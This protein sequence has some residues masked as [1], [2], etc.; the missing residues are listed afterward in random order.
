[1]SQNVHEDYW[2]ISEME[3]RFN[4]TQSGVRTVASTW[5]LAAFGAI[6]VLIRSEDGVTWFFHSH[7]LIVVVSTMASLGLFAL[8]I[9]DQV[10]FQRLLNSAFLVG[11]KMEHD[12]PTIPPV[13]SVMTYAAEGVGMSRWL[14][15]FYFMPMIAFLVLSSWLTLLFD[16]GLSLPAKETTPAI[17]NPLPYMIVLTVLQAIFIVLML[18]K[19]QDISIAKRAALFGDDRFTKLFADKRFQ[20]DAVVGNYSAKEEPPREAAS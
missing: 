16:P 1:M 4:A 12:N 7:M 3:Q 8:W 15:L 18:H 13:R 17:Q 14:R 20:A 10:V 19:A 9:V 11:L 5:M 6:A 2:K